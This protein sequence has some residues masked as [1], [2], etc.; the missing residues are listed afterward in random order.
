M[1]HEFVCVRVIIIVVVRVIRIVVVR[2]IIIVVVRVMR[3]V[4]DVMWLNAFIYATRWAATQSLLLAE[5]TDRPNPFERRN[6]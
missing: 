6:G 2:V 3:M 4:I 1:K 5:Q